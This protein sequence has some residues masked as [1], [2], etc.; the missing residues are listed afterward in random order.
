MIR[1]KVRNKDA[2][3]EIGLASR[4]QIARQVAAVVDTGYNG[5]LTLPSGLISA[6]QLPFVGHRRSR[7]ADGN[8]VVLEVYEAVVVWHGRPR[9]VLILQ[10]EGS[11]LLGMSLLEGS[12]L[13]I[14]VSNDGDG[15]IDELPGGP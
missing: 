3:V 4:S 11:P 8:V 6:L 14:D 12:R 15:T 7:L 1:G 5:S 10:A 2:V 13:T 9:E